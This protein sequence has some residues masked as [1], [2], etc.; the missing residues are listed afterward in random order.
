MTL[1]LILTSLVCVK[2]KDT[3]RLVTCMGYVLSV[4]PPGDVLEYLNLILTPHLVQLQQL[5][6]AEVGASACSR[7]L[8]YYVLLVI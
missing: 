5:A 7:K 2:G 8:I 6:S 3:V 4:L 1:T